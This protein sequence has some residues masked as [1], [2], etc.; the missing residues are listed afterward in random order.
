MNVF[1]DHALIISLILVLFVI[2]LLL[3][4]LEGKLKA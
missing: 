1:Q 2:G 3:H 4:S